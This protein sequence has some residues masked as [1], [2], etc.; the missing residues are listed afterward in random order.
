MD[1]FVDFFNGV[2]DFFWWIHDFITN[3]AYL[4]FKEVMVFAT[5]K[6]IEGGIAFTI[7]ALDV[8]YQV[9]QD[10]LVDLGIT[11]AIE[12]AFSAIP[13]DI[14]SILDFFHVPLCIQ[15]VI[16]GLGTRF[17]LGFVPFYK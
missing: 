4:L 13:S 5:K 1:F 14:Y 2:N 15:N 6:M 12:S 10:Y 17:A 16:L 8:A 9:A 11:A 3:G 7:F